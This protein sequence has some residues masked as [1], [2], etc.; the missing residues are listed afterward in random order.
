MKIIPGVPAVAQ[1]VS[2]QCQDSGSIPGLA[3]W[4][5][6]LHMPKGGK[7]EK[8]RKKKNLRQK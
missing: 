4:A 6:E 1:Q 8:K 2:L 5:Q 7:K 3:Q